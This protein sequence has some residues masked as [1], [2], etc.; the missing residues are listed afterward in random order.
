MASRFGSKALNYATLRDV[1]FTSKTFGDI[2]SYWTWKIWKEHWQSLPTR[3]SIPNG[4]APVCANTM[5]WT[6]IMKAHHA[7][8]KVRE[9][10]ERSLYSYRNKPFGAISASFFQSIGITCALHA[11]AMCTLAQSVLDCGCFVTKWNLPEMT[12]SNPVF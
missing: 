3:S 6:T 8:S 11:S 9:H 1:L 7:C 4:R 2:L 5:V 10:F 12:T